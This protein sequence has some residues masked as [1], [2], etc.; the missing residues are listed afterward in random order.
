MRISASSLAVGQHK[1]AEAVA[2]KNVALADPAVLV[3][4]GRV[5]EPVAGEGEVLPQG[6]QRV[7]AGI[8]VAVEA[9][10][11]LGRVGRLW[12]T[13]AGAFAGT[14]GDSKARTAARMV[15][16]ESHGKV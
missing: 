6:G 7:V 4:A 8:V 9:D 2:Q 14:D 5:G 15:A 3:L 13:G 11:A 12:M 1:E 16:Q 10:R